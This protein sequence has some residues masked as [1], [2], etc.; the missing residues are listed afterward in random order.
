MSWA[1]YNEGA[2]R[3]PFMGR[4]RQKKKLQ[5]LSINQQAE[6]LQD[7]FVQTWLW[8]WENEL[9]FFSLDST[10]KV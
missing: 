10:F 6:Y 7:F 5:A 2:H 9:N 1:L 8:I 4:Q 3:I